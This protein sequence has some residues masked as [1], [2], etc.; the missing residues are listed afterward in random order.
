MGP[1]DEDVLQD[2][3]IPDL[4]KLTHQFDAVQAGSAILCRA[5]LKSEELHTYI[6]RKIKS[7]GNRRAISSSPRFAQLHRVLAAEPPIRSSPTPAR[8][9]FHLHHNIFDTI[10]GD[11]VTRPIR[12][13]SEAGYRSACVTPDP[14]FP[15]HA[16]L[17]QSQA[18]ANMTWPPLHPGQDAIVIVG[19]GIIGLDV[20][21][22][23]ARRGLGRHITVV[24]EHLPGDI[25]PAYTSPWAGCNFSGISGRDRNAL[26][27]D[28]LGYAHLTDLATHAEAESFV[29]R[30][31]SVE[32]W[33]EDAPHDK[34][35]AISEYLEDFKVIP[36]AN[37][38]PGVGY[39]ITCT[40]ITINAP[41]H[42]VYLHHLLKHHHGVRFIRQT[43]PSIHA[44]RLS[45]QTRIV[46][47]CTGNAAR[48]LPGVLDTK[49]YPTR[50]QVVLARAPAMKRNV[51]RHGRDYETYVIPRPG[52]NGN[53]VLGGYMQK[54]NSDP[55]TYGHETESILRRTQELC[56]A[57]LRDSPCELLAVFAGARPSREG[58]ARVERDELPGWDGLDSPAGPDDSGTRGACALVHN[59]GAGGTGFQAGYGMALD[60]VAAVEDVVAGLE[61]LS[62]EPI[63]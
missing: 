5:A 10:G 56:P 7:N 34:I 22:V 58:G 15:P 3:I 44:A 41:K 26:R 35:K 1:M 42:L 63:F 24:A 23:L 12:V 47:N 2:M 4:L 33:D 61:R 52:S 13:P 53:V 21:L 60:A 59:Y 17:G 37:L 46:F 54:G 45:A 11:G 55:S 40:S 31:E 32:Y 43:L 48:T 27:W 6:S 50:G 8:G 30:T 9:F 51:M 16:R 57:E 29:S 14:K 39:G 38:P 18:G 25:S 20:A 36:E 49:C 19:A 62:D 28:K